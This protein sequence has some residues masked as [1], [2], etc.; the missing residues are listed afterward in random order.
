M[1]INIDPK[2]ELFKWGPIEFRLIYGSGFME[3]I[4]V[5]M[6]ESKYY[7]WPW[8]PS[9]CILENGK[10][11]WINE[12]LA[13]CKTGLKYFSKYFLN[14][15][16]YQ[17]HWQWWKKWIKEYKNVV[18]I[19]SGLD[20]KKLTDKELYKY[21]KLFYDFNGEFW[22]IVHVPEIANWGGEYLLKSILKTKFGQKAEEYLEILSTPI[23]FSF[24]Q[25]EELD[26]LKI[27]LIK[28]PR[29]KQQALAK[30]TNNY[31]W[32]L[33][34]YGGNRILKKE[35]FEKKL[36][37]LIKEKI[38]QKKIAEINNAIKNN[39]IRKIRLAKKLGI[40]KQIALIAN[41][42][43]QSI[44]WQDLRKSYIW[45]MSFF[46]DK[47][48]KEISKRTDWEFEELLWCWFYEIL[49]IL[50]SGKIDRKDILKR[51]KYY[52]FYSKNGKTKEFNN[53]EQV[54]K[55]SNTYLKTEIKN[56]KE[57]KGLVVS[58]GKTNII[59][60]KVKI[61]SNPFLESKKMKKG[62]ILVAGMTSPEYIIA[63]RKA[64]AVITDH[65]GMTAHAAIVSRELNI[66]CIVNTKIATKVLKDGD[67]IEVDTN[68]GIVKKL[69]F[70]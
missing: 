49:D 46:I 9:L 41:Q 62:D 15:K 27:G 40:N 43:S 31:S 20:L 16:N 69:S 66:P 47:F 65:G 39:K 26:L 57:L 28:N 64:A 61:I 3:F 63:M 8:P 30:H 37:L 58:R 34:S 22:L 19:L 38:P 48:L 53:K 54:E 6:I 33:N 68:K 59:S 67:L 42:L 36:N 18:R 35:Y 50:K 1:K 52:A 7:P 14:L 55:L 32:L 10:M 70:L 56:I 23:K 29:I 21:A 12:N 4:L 11:T 45:Q 2:K 44:W 51:K 13:V 24:F 60:G 25:Q 5:K 17:K